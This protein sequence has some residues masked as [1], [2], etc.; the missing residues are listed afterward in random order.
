MGRGGKEEEGLI[1]R[2]EAALIEASTTV[3]PGF[4]SAFIPAHLASPKKSQ[5]RMSLLTLLLKSLT[6]LPSL[7]KADVLLMDRTTEEVLEGN[8]ES[9]IGLVGKGE[10]AMRAEEW[11]EAVR[12]F[13][14]AFELQGQSDTDVSTTIFPQ[15]S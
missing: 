10:K 1:K 11:E 6:R 5:L 14:R 3:H 12:S 4:T 15:S 7:S 8:G 2:F 9:V 13:Q